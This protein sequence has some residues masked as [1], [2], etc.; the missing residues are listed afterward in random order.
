MFAGT[1]KEFCMDK[2]PIYDLSCGVFLLATKSGEK[3]NAC[4][5][6]TCMQVASDPVRIA[7]SCLNNNYTCQLLKESGLFT[8]SLLDETVTFE[9]I[10]YFGYQSG[11]NVDKIGRLNLPVAENGIPYLGWQACGVIDGKVID[12]YDLTTHTLFV[13]EVTE[14]KTL[15]DKKPLT[16]ADY[17]SRIKPKTVVATGKKIIG[18]RCK[19]CGYVYEKPEL[20]T[21]FS[22]PICGHTAEDFEP[23][24]E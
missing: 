21:D 23:I 12:S 20:P 2:K 1:Q 14:A 15:S 11:R 6:N 22:C 9:T 10:R 3:K 5:T 19:I 17:Q 24:Y 8:L 16:Y 13:A 7:V 4:I 18:W